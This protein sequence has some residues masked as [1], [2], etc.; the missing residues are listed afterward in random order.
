MP[1]YAYKCK[2]CDFETEV[3]QQMGANKLDCP[4]CKVSMSKKPTC[5]SFVYMK[6]R[7]GY[8][9]FRKQ[10]L[11]TAPGTTRITGFENKG[12]PGSKLP[13]AKIEGEKWLES[14]E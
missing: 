13:E 10:Y 1:I 8:P 14:I 2:N 11:G 9:S 6:G 5:H 7:G 3:I 12:G 4:K